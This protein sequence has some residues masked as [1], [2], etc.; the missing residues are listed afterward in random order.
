MMAQVA[1]RQWMKLA[2]V[3]QR[4]RGAASNAVEILKY[5]YT[6]TQMQH[7]ELAVASPRDAPEAAMYFVRSAELRQVPANC[8]TLYLTGTA[9]EAA[10]H[11]IVAELPARSLVVDYC[12]QLEVGDFGLQPKLAIEREVLESWRLIEAFLAAQ[13]IDVRL[14]AVTAGATEAFDDALDVLMGVEAEFLALAGVFQRVLDLARP[15]KTIPKLARDEYEILLMLAHRVQT[16]SSNGFSPH[17]LSTYADDAFF[18]SDKLR[19]AESVAEAIVR[20]EQAGRWRLVRILMAQTGEA[21]PGVD[22]RR[23]YRGW[24]QQPAKWLAMAG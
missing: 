8:L 5:T 14:L 3:L 19:A 10:V 9:A 4:R 7:L 6:I 15:L 1:R 12:G 21:V 2:R 18:L 11:R 13:S 24:P 23:V 16:F 22:G 17:F 20:H